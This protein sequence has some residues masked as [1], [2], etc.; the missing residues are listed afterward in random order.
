MRRLV[1]L[2]LRR[3]AGGNLGGE[4]Q[5]LVGGVAHG[6]HDDGDLVARQLGGDDA[7]RDATQRLG[8]G[9][10][11]SAELHH[12]QSHGTSWEVFRKGG[13]GALTAAS[14]VPGRTSVGLR[15]GAS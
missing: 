2:A 4:V 9:D 10:G 7:T 14:G 5:Q 1:Q 13:R 8:V 15:H 11:R 3:D 12:E 6:G